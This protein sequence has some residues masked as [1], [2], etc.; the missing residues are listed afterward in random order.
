MNK[1]LRR[2]VADDLDLVRS[3]RNHTNVKRF[4]FTQDDISAE[5]H[6][7]WYQRVQCDNSKNILIYTENDIPS[8]FVQFSGIRHQQKI[9]DWGFYIA[10]N[11]EPG[12]GTRMTTTALDFAFKQLQ[13]HK[14][15]AEILDSN[16][17]SIRLHH[18]LGFAQEGF[19]KD[20]HYDGRNYCS[21]LCFGLLNPL[22]N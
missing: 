14:V 21:V 4:L 1:F 15:F 5:D 12:T 3:W 18:K 17:A 10:P 22:V 9:V 16:A 20:H 13:I 2:M 19:L 7:A 8:G 6:I 11:S